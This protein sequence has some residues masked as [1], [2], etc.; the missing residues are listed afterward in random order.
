MAT[1]SVLSSD[2]A[3]VVKSAVWALHSVDDAVRDRVHH[4]FEGAQDRSN[5]LADE[6][7]GGEEARFA[8]EDVEQRLVHLD[9]VPEGRRRWRPRPDRRRQVSCPA[10]Y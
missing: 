7:D 9:K 4:L 3:A 1:L 10:S 5:G 8:D 2:A 6:G